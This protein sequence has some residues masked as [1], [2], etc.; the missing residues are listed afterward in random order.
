MENSFAIEGIATF[1]D[2]PIN[3]V[4]KADEVAI[5]NTVFFSFTDPPSEH[6]GVPIKRERLP[7]RGP[8]P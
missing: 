4:K 8:F 2:D 7:L 3:G 6:A 1:T 5:N